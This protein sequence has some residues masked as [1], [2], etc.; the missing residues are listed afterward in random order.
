MPSNSP[1]RLPC[2]RLQVPCLMKPAHAASRAGSAGTWMH[3][4]T[5]VSALPAPWIRSDQRIE[6]AS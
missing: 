4:A 1:S 3:G 2:G 6:L 5:W